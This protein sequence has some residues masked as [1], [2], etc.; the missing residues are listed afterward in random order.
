MRGYKR[1]VT[2][3]VRDGV[4]VVHF[5][6]ELEV[7]VEGDDGTTLLRF[8]S[9][10]DAEDDTYEFLTF[11][12]ESASALANSIGGR[13]DIEI[14]IEPDV[15]WGVKGYDRPQQMAD[16]SG[17]LAELSWQSSWTR[18]VAADLYS[19]IYFSDPESA[20]EEARRDAEPYIQRGDP[21]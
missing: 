17:E 18:I 14:D 13:R 10:P 5:P 7:T 2:R 12:K 21:S 9:E 3:R 6:R 15:A 11:P 16:T 8:Q 19:L 20:K 4:V 1:V